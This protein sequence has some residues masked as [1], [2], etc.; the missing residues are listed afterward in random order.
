MDIT[1]V[2]LWI[3]TSFI[4]LGHYPDPK[5]RVLTEAE[6]RDEIAKGNFGGDCEDDLRPKRLSVSNAG[7]GEN[8]VLAQINEVDGYFEDAQPLTSKSKGYNDGQDDL[9]FF[10]RDGNSIFSHK[11]GASQS[12]GDYDGQSFFSENEAEG[13]DGQSYHSRAYE[14]QSYFAQQ[15]RHYEE[16]SVKGTYL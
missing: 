6:I 4:M 3:V 2:V 8:I 1:A 11:E 9:S 5:L 15:S 14:E 16:A 12:N 10:A 13:A 7:P